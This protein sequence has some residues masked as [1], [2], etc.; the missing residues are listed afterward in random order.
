MIK[1]VIQQLTAEDS[2]CVVLCKLSVKGLTLLIHSH[3]NSVAVGD[4]LVMLLPNQGM[5]ASFATVPLPVQ[6]I[7]YLEMTRPVFCQE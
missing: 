2:P 4:L 6:M 5:K 7:I 3:L 1:Q